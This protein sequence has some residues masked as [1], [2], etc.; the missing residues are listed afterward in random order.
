MKTNLSEVPLKHI[1]GVYSQLPAGSSKE[2]FETLV[3]KQLKPLLTMVYN[4]SDIKLLFRLGIS[5]Y[6]YLE[7]FYPE[8]NMLI[9]ELCRR[10][11]ME[12][13]TSSYCDVILSLIPSHERATQIEKTTTYIRKHFSRKPRGLWFYNQV[14][15]PTAIPVVGLC[16]LDYVVI[17]T[18]NQITNITEANKPFY[19]DELGKD[20]LVIPSDDRFSKLTSELYLGGLSL[21][22]YL[23]ECAK[24]A[25]ETTGPIST[26]MLNMNQLM[27]T[28]RSEKVYKTIY[29][30][31]EGECTL[32]SIFIQE[33]EI[34]KTHYLPNGLY[35]RDYSIDSSTS[36]NQLIYDN[37][38]LSRNYGV[39]NMLRDV[40]RES[41][42]T[43]DGRKNI[44]NLLMMASCS[45][46]YF[47]NECKTPAILRYSNRFACEIE[48][49]LA[50]TPGISF[51][52]ETDV[53][54]DRVKEFLIVNKS[55]ISYL[56]RKGAVLSRHTI[57]SA[58]FDL[59]FHSGEGM[60]VDSFIPTGAVAT[61]KNETR[62]VSQNYEVT[63]LDKKNSD[64]F[65]K[66]P[67]VSL[68]KISVSLTKRFKFR[69]SN[70]II[71]VEIENLSDIR[72]KGFTYVNTINLGLPVRC[73]CTSPEGEIP[74]GG[75]ATT[76]SVTLSDRH[77]PFTV[78]F[79]MGEDVVISRNDF[80]MKTH[81]WLGDK[82]FYEYTQLRIQ[83][84]LSLGP[85]EAC[86]LT[87]GFKTEKR[88]EKHNDTTE[89]SAP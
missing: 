66:A 55:G 71:E 74:D 12:I 50:N 45:S 3:S 20:V 19:T 11:Q 67:T 86:R 44:D 34:G 23:S 33:N 28:D 17:S 70:M 88:K 77:C 75:S 38:M 21:D 24:A 84:Q 80:E 58:L 60:F 7:T 36:I 78:Q 51:P 85:Y 32:P 76:Q 2:E 29:E 6:D 69:Q 4:I 22:R 35:G 54:F 64:F 57:P 26:I 61:N 41:K 10:G 81:T 15:N 27:A 42:K 43:I 65:A 18:Y 52:E 87:I 83:K 9:N 72:L 31:L 56:N 89:Q 82:S 48:S 37:P 5:E 62:L 79:V 49:T 39:V 40:I 30:N 25:K 46:L 59:A 68:G 53:D 47:P 8:I 63:P 16:G 14:F 1:L 13:L 73:A